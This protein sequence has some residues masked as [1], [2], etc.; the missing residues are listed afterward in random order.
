[1]EFVPPTGYITSPQSAGAD[2][3]VDSNINQTTNKSDTVSLAAGATDTTIDAGFYIPASIAG[4]VW[5]DTNKDGINDASE[6]ESVSGI[7]VSLVDANGVS[8]NN[9]LTGQPYTVT[10]DAQGNYLF[11]NLPAGDYQVQFSTDGYDVSPQD[12]GGDDAKDSD[13]DLLTFKTGTITLNTGD[14]SVNNDAGVK[15]KSSGSSGSKSKP[16]SYTCKNS[17]ASNFSNTGIHKE[18][19]CTYGVESEVGEIIIDEEEDTETLL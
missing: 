17:K 4:T 13:I 2:T 14:S 6:T 3:A 12:A 1:M 19:L 8:V 5:S 18:S 15:K 9:P 16:K 10:T 7:T 11:E